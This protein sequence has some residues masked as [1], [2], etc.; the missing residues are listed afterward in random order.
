MLSFVT[1]Q[2]YNQ[3]IIIII[4]IIRKSHRHFTADVLKN[5]Q[6]FTPKD[7]ENL[8]LA[9]L[10]AEQHRQKGKRQN[11]KK[12]D[13]VKETLAMKD[14]EVVNSGLIGISERG[15]CVVMLFNIL[16]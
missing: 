6:I 11:E 8:R 15:A 10:K 16:C 14:S 13:D 2:S 5:Q 12:G 9:K 3:S 1:C 7:F 4:N